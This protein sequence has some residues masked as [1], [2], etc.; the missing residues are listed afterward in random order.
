MSFLRDDNN[1]QTPNVEIKEE[2]YDE[3]QEDAIVTGAECENGYFQLMGDTQNPDE[4]SSLHPQEEPQAEREL[5]LP[6]TTDG[7]G[8]ATSIDSGNT[9]SVDATE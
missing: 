3:I 7:D 6:P 2:I 1:E 9:L 8:N 4:Y 5:G